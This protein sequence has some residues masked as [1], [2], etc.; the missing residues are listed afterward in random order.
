MQPSTH[1]LCIILGNIANL[2][3]ILQAKLMAKT[4]RDY[5]VSGQIK[6]LSM[7]CLARITFVIVQTITRHIVM[8]LS[9]SAA[10]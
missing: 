4:H 6:L 2:M 5:T 9:Y 10:L 3:H 8:R 7:R 1:R